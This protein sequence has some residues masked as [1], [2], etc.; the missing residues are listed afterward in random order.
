LKAL[1]KIQVW[2]GYYNAALGAIKQEDSTRRI[3]RN[4]SVQD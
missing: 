2:Q 4:V 3:D 1:D